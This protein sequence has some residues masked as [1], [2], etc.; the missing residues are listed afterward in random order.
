MIV[1]GIDVGTTGTKTIALNENGAIVGRGY[2]EYNLDSRAGGFVEQDARDW[3]RAVVSTVAEATRYI[4][5][6]SEIIAISVSSQG[7]TMTAVDSSSE[8]LCPAITWMDGRALHESEFLKNSIGDDRFYRKCGWSAG[9][10]CDIAK[11][12]WLKNNRPD[13][14][15]N[16][17]CFVSTIEYINHMLTGRYVAD[18]TNASIRGM[19]NINTM[20]WDSEVLEAAGTDISLLPDVLPT[21]SYIGTLT[22]E[23]ASLL[24]LGCGVRVYN[25]AHDQYCAALGCGATED[26]DM[27]LSTG[28][29][30]VVLGVT[31]KP[32]YTE[33]H[34]SP[35]I[36]PCGGLYGAMASLTT[37][38]SALKWY[39][40]LIGSESYAD[41]DRY[42]AQCRENASDLY[43]MPYIAGAGFPDRISDMGGCAVGMRLHH[44][45]YDIALALMEGVAFETRNALDEY[46][47]SGI[48]IKRL[49]MVGGAAKSV[50]WSSLVGYITGCEITRMSESEGCALGAA[51]IAAVNY[52]IFGDYRT[53]A[54]YCISGDRLTTSDAQVRNYYDSKY[55]KYNM[56]AR[57]IKGVVT[58]GELFRAH[59][60]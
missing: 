20:E 17:R 48:N 14:Y 30:W 9:P 11:I 57:T 31:G 60:A 1:L 21:G 49:R 50:L 18:P 55:E 54:D 5:D 42:A 37:A 59:K 6:R 45:K 15:K 8:P 29:T 25:G 2:R 28:T 58:N 3:S 46:R 19:Y 38:G 10:S 7:A 52:G 12:M 47:R 53:A 24:R 34:I 32:V 22:D 44:T 13:I 40:G 35:G 41:I 4:K 56:L 43:F 51:L 33:S 39:R 23:A 16:T 26:G 36:H 27:L